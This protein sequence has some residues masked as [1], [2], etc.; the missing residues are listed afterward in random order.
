M[1]QGLGEARTHLA[2]SFE[3]LVGEVLCKE[4]KHEV[5]ALGVR[6]ELPPEQEAAG[7]ELGIWQL[8]LPWLRD[9]KQQYLLL[10]GS[11]CPRDIWAHQ[12][13]WPKQEAQS[14]LLRTTS[15]PPPSNS[16]DQKTLEVFMGE[17]A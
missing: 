1:A 4:G 6:Y 7:Q 17:V 3:E 12:A 16:L 14:G 5:R 10:S 9:R 8:L 2:R 15:P 13:N 11:C